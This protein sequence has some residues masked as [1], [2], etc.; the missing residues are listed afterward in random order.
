MPNKAI[1]LIEDNE[2]DELLTLRAIATNGIVNPVVVA[3]D[4]EEALQILFGDDQTRPLRPAVVILD[5]RLPKVSGFEVLQRLRASEL[6]KLLPVVIMTSSKEDQ[7]VV[8]G[9]RFGANS[10]VRKPVKFEELVKAINSLGMYWLLLN[11]HP[12]RSL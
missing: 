11:E 12:D 4:G 8:D 2:V 5:L 1:L 9:Y 6:T 7:D 3:R 10:F